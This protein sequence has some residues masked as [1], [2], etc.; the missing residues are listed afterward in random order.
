MEPLQ[1]GWQPGTR[2]FALL[3]PRA[4]RVELLQCAHPAQA[5]TATRTTCVVQNSPWGKVFV[6]SGADPAQLRYYR[7][8]VEQD[9][10]TVELA[11]PWGLAQA[12]QVR[13]GTPTWSVAQALPHRHQRPHVCLPMAE[14]VVLEAHVRDAT[15]LWTHPPEGVRPG[16]YRALAHADSPLLAH[17]H[18]LSV[19]ALEL[20]PLATWPL[21]EPSP[22]EPDAQG[23]QWNP[24]GVNHWG[25]MPSFLLA[26]SERY[27]QH[28]LDDPDAWQ[29]VLDDGSFADPALELREAVD[30]LHAAG[31]AVVVDVVW[32]HVSNADV[33][34][35]LTLDPG[36]WFVRQPDGSLRNHSG[37]GNDLNTAHP[38]MRSLVLAATRRWLGEI[39]VDGLR[40]DLAE[41]IDDQTLREV[42]SLA[43]QLH[44]TPLLFAE[45]WSLGGYR[46]AQLAQLGYSVWNDR[47]RNGW[48][49]HHPQHGQGLALGSTAGGAGLLDALALVRGWPS[50]P[51][52]RH[53][54]PTPHADLA[55]LDRQVHYLES[56]DDHTAGDFVRLA[57][58]IAPTGADW[59]ALYPL[60][61][62]ELRVQQ[63]LAAVLCLSAGPLLIAAGQ[64]WAR[65]RLGSDG[66]LTGN[67][68][69][70]DDA[71]SHLDWRGPQL[72]QALH[73]WWQALLRLRRQWLQPGLGES[74]RWLPWLPEHEGGVGWLQRT[75]RGDA[76]VALNLDAA[77]ERWWS[78]PGGPWQ[79]LLANDPAV[80]IVPTAHGVALR[81]P[82][83]AVAV[84]VRT[85]GH[86]SIAHTG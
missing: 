30:A 62:E 28:Y 5:H 74:G 53:L 44:P 66:V 67:A 64:S 31:L 24:T 75:V 82:A 80:D 63:R 10:Q 36:D 12:R 35:L 51:L 16:T 18:S 39:G 13:L 19:T 68:W 22:H 26:V 52:A 9:G 17:A 76:A 27:S 71:T 84:F 50:E 69:N 25:Y 83:G 21:R 57:L 65:P 40:L 2:R 3:A 86:S 4:D 49:G 11:D 42:H 23:Q 48:K 43:H 61:P 81:V 32:N 38:A 60:R 78:L 72:G 7:F 58:G 79:V 1:L 56:H 20:L 85:A 77:A 73:G 41:L 15:L 14:Q 34:P 54:R 8:S 45:P 33:Q 6:A 46:P 37:C 55:P 70:R 29:G 59:T 47:F